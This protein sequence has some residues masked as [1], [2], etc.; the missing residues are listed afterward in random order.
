MPVDSKLLIH[1]GYDAVGIERRVWIDRPGFQGLIWYGNLHNARELFDYYYSLGITHV[2]LDVREDH[3]AV[4]Q[5]EI[6]LRTLLRR[7][8]TPK[9]TFGAYHLFALPKDPPPAEKAYTVLAL[10]VTAYTPG[11]YPIER[12]NTVEYLGGEWKQY[13]APDTTAPPEN[14]AA[15]LGTVNVVVMRRGYPVSPEFQSQLSAQ[16]Q[17]V[18]EWAGDSSL[19]IRR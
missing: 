13:G 10:G 3:P 18:D 8:S 11:V 14:V 2:A 6:I 16:F 7:H 17:T 4:V 5:D 1:L 9:G 12:L 15:L 19:F